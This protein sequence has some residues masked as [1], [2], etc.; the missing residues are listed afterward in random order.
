[1]S[2]QV[3]VLQMGTITS[4]DAENK[5]FSEFNLINSQQNI[6]RKDLPQPDKTHL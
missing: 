4:I 5:F 1:M 3:W 6:N 2:N